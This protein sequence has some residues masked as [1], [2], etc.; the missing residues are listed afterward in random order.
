M[1]IQDIKRQLAKPATR[2]EAGGFRPTDSLQESWLG[3]V[4]LFRPDEQIPTN[5]AGQPLIPYAQFY[6]PALPYVSPLLDGVSVMTVFIS[7]PLP[8]GEEPMG[9]NWLIR[10]Y[11]ADDELVRKDLS[12]DTFLKPFA[13][14]ATLVEA[15]YPLWDGGGVPRALELEV[16]KLEDDGVIESYY[17]LIDHTYDHKIG[18]YPSFCQS[19]IDPGDDYEFVFQISTDDKIQ[20]NVIDNGSLMFWKHKTTGEW[21]LYYDFH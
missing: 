8:D 11:T 9:E 15:D 14:K 1:D 21:F 4:F 5:A 12:V 18:G 13:L 2:F 20:L 6:L 10:E 17:D 7:E 16:L 19:G 3:K